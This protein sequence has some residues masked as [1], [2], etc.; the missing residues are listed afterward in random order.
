MYY[1][2]PLFT[3]LPRAVNLGNLQ[4]AEDASLV[5]AAGQRLWLS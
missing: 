2:V 5:V 1:R 4:K 3:Q